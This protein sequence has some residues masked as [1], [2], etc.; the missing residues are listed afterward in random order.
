MDHFQGHFSSIRN[1][2]AK[3]K[4]ILPDHFNQF[5][6]HGVE[7]ISIFI[8]DFINKATTG[9]TTKALRLKIQQN[10]IHRLKLVFPNGLN[11]YM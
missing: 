3:Q 8:L 9:S 10:W 5:D 2:K 7:D 1:A 11:L 6:H 4:T